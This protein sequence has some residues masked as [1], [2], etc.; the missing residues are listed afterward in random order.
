M[1][2][3]LECKVCLS[4]SESDNME[5]VEWYFGSED[6]EKL[7]PIDITEHILVSPQDKTLHLYNL[8]VEQ[9]GQYVCQLNGQLTAP[10]FV[11]VVSDEEPLRQVSPSALS[12][13]ND[14]N[15]CFV[16]GPTVQC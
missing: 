10:Y 16:L 8:A 3:R 12:V 7:L 5:L 6:S 2:C 1:F 9:T 14:K 11:T 15:R 4:P 13:P